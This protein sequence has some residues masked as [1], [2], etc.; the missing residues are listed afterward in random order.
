[1]ADDITLSREYF[2]MLLRRAQCMQQAASEYAALK[3]AL[4][5]AGTPLESIKVLVNAAS[6]IPT[7]PEDD[8]DSIDEEDSLSDIEDTYIPA[9]RQDFRQLFTKPVNARFAASGPWRRNVSAPLS[10]TSNK[11]ENFADHFDTD[12]A[13]VKEERFITDRGD[14]SLV[15]KGLSKS[16]TLEDITK[17]IRGGMVLNLF[18]RQHLQEAHVAFV[19][20]DDAEKFL[21]HA[22]RHDFYIKSKRV[23]VSWDERQHYMPGGI[24][25]RI[26]NDGASRNLVIRFPK[27]EVTE[28][29]VRDDLDHINTLE[30]VSVKTLQGHIFVSLN[31]VRHALA[32]RSCMMHR[33]RYKGSR[34]EFWPD[35][36]AEPFPPVP[37]RPPPNQNYHKHQAKHSTNSI[38][39]FNVLCNEDDT[40][41]TAYET[42][43]SG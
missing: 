38:N 15:I 13:P 22:K 39:R 5:T 21:L 30:V 37:R 16:T 23:H 43:E 28:Q 19:N 18:V 11:Q 27:P 26:H 25:R 40:S 41:D 7:P 42:V 14:R 1:M 35:A 3:H 31:S 9:H 10:P 6:G 17:A 24:A 29:V 33:L 32:A 36:C 8:S 34:V 20:T 2:L 4:V 12:L